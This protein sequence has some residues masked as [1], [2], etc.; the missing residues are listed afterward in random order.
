MRSSYV[1]TGT[2]SG[3]LWWPVGQISTHTFTY[4]WARQPGEDCRPD[5]ATLVNA[6]LT[7]EDGD[8]K[9]GIMLLGDTILTV[10]RWRHDDRGHRSR[11]FDLNHFPSLADVTSHAWPL[12]EAEA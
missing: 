6:V 8:Y 1:L 3:L 2:I 10:T 4:R 5:L 7:Q 12:E 9:S 11:T